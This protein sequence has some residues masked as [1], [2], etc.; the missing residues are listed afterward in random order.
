M[1]TIQLEG[2]VGDSS[3]KKD[4]KPAENSTSEHV[5]ENSKIVYLN[6]SYDLDTIPLDVET[7]I[8]FDDNDKTM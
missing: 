1:R 5:T 6:D 3:T 8:D 4:E 7:I 2:N